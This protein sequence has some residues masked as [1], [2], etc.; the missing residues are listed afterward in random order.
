MGHFLIHNRLT[1][2]FVLAPLSLIGVKLPSRNSGYDSRSW[3]K[4]FR[5]SFCCSSCICLSNCSETI[6]STTM[7]V[8]MYLRSLK[9]YSV[10]ETIKRMTP[11]TKVYSLARTPM[12]QTSWCQ[13]NQRMYLKGN[14]PVLAKWLVC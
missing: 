13:I 9:R 5:C 3:K 8:N 10:P 1:K 14:Q 7:A 4:C 12:N 2:N 11:K 6:R